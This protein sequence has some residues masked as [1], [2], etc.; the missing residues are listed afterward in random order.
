MPN[1]LTGDFDV[2]A[3]FGVPA[4]DRIL[5]AMHSVERF[6]HSLTLR[7]DDFK[8]PERPFPGPSVIGVVDEFGDAVANQQHIGRPHIPPE[9]LGTGD[10]TASR[11]DAIVNLHDLLVDVIDIEPSN[12]KGRAQLQLAPPVI[13]IL[14]NSGSN[15]TVRID[16]MA[17]YFPDPGSPRVAEF[18]KGELRITA[19]VNQVAS[20]QGSMIKVDI[21]GAGLSVSFTPKWSSTPIDANDLAAINLLVLNAIRTG[22]LPATNPMPE[23]ISHIQFKAMQGVRQ[24]VALLLNVNGGPG[25]RASANSLFLGAADD[26]AFAAGSDFVRAAFQ[27][28]LDKILGNPVPDAKFSLDGLVHTWHITYKFQLY[29]AN[30]ELKPGAIVMVITGHASTSSWTPNFDFT[31]KLSFSLAPTGDT[32]DLVPGDVSIDTSSWIINRF[33]G[34]AEDAIRSSRDSALNQGNARQSVRDMLS[35]DRNIGALLDSLI[36]P[37]RTGGQPPLP[38]MTRLWYNS[39]EIGPSGI[40]LHG[41]IA[42]S[43]WPQAHVAFEQIPMNAGGRPDIDASSV[44]EGADYSALKT[45]I[46]GGEIQS[47]E[48]K[49]FG[50]AQQG[51]IDQNRFV[52]LHQGPVSSAGELARSPVVVGYRP[53]CVTVR[54]LRIS[55][56]GPAVPQEVTTTSCAWNFFPVIGALEEGVAPPMMAL[57]TP[58]DHGVVEVIGHSAARAATRARK[59]PN[60]LIHFISREGSSN[61]DALP[62][63]VM[64]SGR[65]DAPAAIVVVAPEEVL[66]RVK[67]NDSV[68]YSADDE[69]WRR[70]LDIDGSRQAVTALVDPSGK[71]KWK[72]AGDIDQSKLTSMLRESLVS[73]P[74]V[75]SHLRPPILRIGSPPPNFLFHFDSDNEST[76]RKLAG[77]EVKVNFTDRGERRAVTV[78][79]GKAT[80]QVDDREGVIAKAYG[81]DAWPTTVVIDRRGL[82][83]SIHVGT[84][85]ESAEALSSHTGKEKGR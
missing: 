74:G 1:D 60:L 2:I 49:R 22:F 81:V 43:P 13:E 24:A 5:A 83:E 56:S 35:A 63:A 4:V 33:R 76:L 75:S 38:K 14:D 67:F 41:S 58:G 39:V 47:Y 46:P 19:P 85:H 16:L 52:M 17:R 11:L 7:V 79:T 20:Q 8:S 68:V 26:F 12:L 31:V 72:H 80:A 18:V 51:Y 30:V 45:W 3:Q 71:V 69:A 32:V 23:G 64:D 48:W 78:E 53:M 70:R 28:T 82:V 57:S 6:P 66:R 9:F 59:P 42:V 54:G 21:R 73:A 55:A 44:N 40:T 10:S 27:P 34:T 36:Q 62:Q 29:T 65:P 61:V 77:R 50:Q 84:L 37:A 25:D 15:V